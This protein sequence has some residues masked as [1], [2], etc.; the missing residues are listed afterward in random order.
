MSDY[1]DFDPYDFGNDTERTK[2]IVI[3][4]IISAPSHKERKRRYNTRHPIFPQR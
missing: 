1:N 4:S 3:S 2:T